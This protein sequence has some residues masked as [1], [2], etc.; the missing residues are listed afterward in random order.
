LRVVLFVFRKT[1]A[2]KTTVFFPSD[3]KRFTFGV[4]WFGDR[5]SPPATRALPAS[6]LCLG[7]KGRPVIGPRACRS[8]HE[9]H[10]PRSAGPTSGAPSAT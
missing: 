7:P 5:G 2:T 8:T 9:V 4:A 10:K 3:W 6:G 1:R